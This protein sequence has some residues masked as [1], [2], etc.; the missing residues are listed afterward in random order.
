MS[1]PRSLQL[2][3]GA[4]R[5]SL[6]HVGAIEVPA[7]GSVRG[8]ALLVPGFT[9]GAEDFIHLL[10]PL[11][12]LGWHVVA[13]DLPGQQ[14]SPGPDVE[15]AYTLDALGAKIAAL[16]ADL[17][18]PHV[19]GHSLGGLVVQRAVQHGAQPASVTLLC[20]GAGAL[21]SDRH[22]PLP[23]LMGVL[24]AMPLDEIWA[25]KE[26]LD[27]EQGWDPSPEVYEFMKQRFV[28]HNPYALRAMTQI[29]LEHDLLE[30]LPTQLPVL[31][32]FG[33][34]DDAWTLEHQHALAERHDGL[35]VRIANAG[36]SP[37]VDQP[38]HTAALLS[39]FWRAT[40]G[41][42]TDRAGYHADVDVQC[43]LPHDAS[44][45]QLARAQVAT[46]SD[47]DTA[48]LIATELVANAIAHGAGPISLELAVSDEMLTIRVL[49]ADPHA[50]PLEIDAQD[51]AV[52]GR[53]LALVNALAT[54]WGWS[55]DQQGKTVWASV[56]LA[57]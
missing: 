44:A 13:I 1:T 4:R 43:A 22:G 48:A 15:L 42:G 51:F 3:V 26:Q 34:E 28:D 21:P 8:T 32:A 39:E 49:D 7:N 57:T 54:D 29:L 41:F 12:R 30:T 56:S 35:A 36:H 46:V 23:L 47:S 16:I 50:I 31:I 20:S 27:R 53:G 6:D 17:D 33:A 19:V 5:T 14:R 2:P 40:H 11:A 24:P 18:V 55:R 37:A 25:V 9:G 45:A 10:D 52:S 38:E